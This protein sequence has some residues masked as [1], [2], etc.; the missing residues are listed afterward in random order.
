MDKP[1]K[2]MTQA[3]RFFATLALALPLAIVACGGDQG[4]T[5]PVTPPPPPWKNVAATLFAASPNTSDGEFG[6][7]DNLVIIG[8]D[9]IDATHGQPILVIKGSYFD[10]D[11]KTHIVDLQETPKRINKTKLT[12]RMFPNI[13]FHPNGDKLGEFV[14]ELRVINQGNDGSQELSTSLP[15]TLRVKPSLIP[16]VMRPLGTNCQPIVEATLEG[17]G[18]SFVFEA[19]GLRAGTQDAPLTFHWTFLRENWTVK[20]SN[21]S[22]DP[23]SILPKTGAFVLEDAVTKGTTSM[24]QDL[25]DRN[26]LLKVGSD[27]FGDT[28][29]K[30]LRTAKI[31][32][33]G[34]SYPASV[35][36]AAVDA[37]GKTARLA[38]SLKVMQMATMTYDGAQKIVERFAPTMVSECIPGGDIGRQVSY[39]EDKAETR[40]RG[41]SF[42]YNANVGVNLGLPSNPFA[43]G[44]NFSAGFGVDVNAS[45]STTKSKGLDLSGQILPG[46][47]GVF[48]RQT[49]KL[50]RVG[51]LVGHTVCG[52]DVDLGEAILTDWIF[53][54]DLAT[55]PQCAPASNLPPAKKFAI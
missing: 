29:L 24:V 8:Q 4:N 14:G 35:N 39:R 7:G 10:S 23:D 31:P 30:E 50:Y 40:G 28:R 16:R 3:T 46:L 55:G 34:D 22:F 32:E 44:L 21:G 52:Q 37:S 6:V 15:V 49:T 19:V 51:H 2:S 54:P 41:M 12:W 36:V 17:T 25:G 47:Y 20:M 42:Q 13:V 48:Y 27:A 43:L 5:T 1:R 26:F 45:S 33:G 11:G 38:I 18:F 9:F 53:T